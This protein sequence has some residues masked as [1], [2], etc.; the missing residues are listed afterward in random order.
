MPNQRAAI[1]FQEAVQRQQKTITDLRNGAAHAVC[2]GWLPMA[3][4]DT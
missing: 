2:A 1:A 4:M 3:V